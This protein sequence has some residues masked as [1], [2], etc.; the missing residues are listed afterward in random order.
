MRRQRL[1]QAPNEINRCI[2]KRADRLLQEYIDKNFPKL[3][4]IEKELVEK[5]QK[6]LKEKI[7]EE[8]RESRTEIERIINNYRDD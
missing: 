4:E 7:R 3:S 8:E 5:C 2:E 6:E 1:N